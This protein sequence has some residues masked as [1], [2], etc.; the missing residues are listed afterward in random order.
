[1]NGVQHNG[2]VAAGR[3]F[4]TCG[5]VKA[6]DHNAVLLVFNGS[7]A[8]GHIGENVRYIAPVFRIKHFICGGEIGFLNGMDQHF[9]HGDQTCKKICSLFRIGLVNDALVTVAGGSRF[10]GVDPGD[11]DQLVPYFFIDLGKAGNIVA[12]C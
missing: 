5:N 7:G 6:A 8:D 10:V 11:Q 12:D 9:S 3:I 4:H 1:M 2:Q